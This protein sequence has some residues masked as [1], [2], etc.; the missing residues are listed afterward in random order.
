M[1]TQVVCLYESCAGALWE[2]VQD[3]NNIYLIYC[4]E[5]VEGH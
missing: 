3:Y 1:L 4:T 2:G 5:K